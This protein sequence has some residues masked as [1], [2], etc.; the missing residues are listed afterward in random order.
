MIHVGVDIAKHV[1]YAAVV[2]SDGE[3]LKEPFS[4]ENNAEGFAAFL[5]AIEDHE[6]RDVLIGMESTAHYGENLLSWLFNKG[7]SVA[8]INPLQTAALR[9]TNL[10]K[11]KTDRTDALLIS[12]FLSVGQYRLYT[13]RDEQTGALK[14]LCRF[15]HNARGTRSRLKTQLA[16]YMDV[17]FPEYAGFFKSGIHSKTSYALL[18]MHPLPDEI[19]SAHLTHLATLLYKASRWHFGKPEAIALRKLASH[20]VGVKDAAMSIQ[21]TQTIAHIELLDS[22]LE[23]LK[24]R[25]ARLVES[26]H[27]PIMTIPG[28]NVVLGGAILGE[29]GD[30]DRFPSPAKLLAYAGL[31]PAT[32]QSGQWNAKTTHMSKRGSSL[33]RYSLMEV[34]WQ[35][36]CR[37]ETFGAYYAKKR[38]QGLTHF[39]ALGH[40]AHKLVRVLFKLLREDIPFAL[41]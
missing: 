8:L 23:D 27:S 24:T 26:L 38:S 11:T 10:R 14:H 39:A 34:A 15:Y 21:I 31:D 32:Y 2:S 28:V 22:Q 16:A 17:V 12:R 4:F 18:K 6:K 29:I 41:A 25:I 9:K 19:A 30:I 1:H 7:Y 13:A 3:V 20:S 40:V 5:S 33:L 37:T 36:S 35:L